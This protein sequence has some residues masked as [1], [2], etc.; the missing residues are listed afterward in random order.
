MHIRS[1]SAAD[2]EAILA[3]VPRLSEQG[4]P[5]GRDRR[6]IEAVD[7]QTIAQALDDDSLSCE[8]LVAE[9]EGAIVGFIHARTTTDY[10]TQAP[11]GHVSDIVVAKGMEGRGVGRALVDAAQE[12][13][14]SRGYALMQLYVLPENTGARGLY[15]SMGYRAEWLKYVRRIE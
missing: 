12:W 6:E 15:E 8:V 7:L 10:Y 3:L 9:D 4:T 13:A 5:S 11:I 14:R 1:A 2:R